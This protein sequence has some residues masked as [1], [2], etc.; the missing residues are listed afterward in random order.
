MAA[1]ASTGLFFIECSS[2]VLKKTT[3][4][5]CD[6]DVQME[7]LRYYFNF[8]AEI[9]SSQRETRRGIENLR[10]A[11][12]QKCNDELRNFTSVSGVSAVL[13]VSAQC[14]RCIGPVYRVYR[15]YQVYRLNVSGVSA[16]LILS[17]QCIR[18][19]GYIGCIECIGSVYQVY[20]VYQL[21]RVY[22][23]SV[24]RLY[25]VYWLSVS[26]V[27]AQCIRCI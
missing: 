7:M 19:I 16:V 23:G 24:Y 10:N 5:E 12:S 17:A 27:S 25:R 2:F 9:N 18:C 11:A 6:R 15:L 13:S 21:Y 26:S 20:R 14:I 8:A 1:V 3:L 4:Y 22:D